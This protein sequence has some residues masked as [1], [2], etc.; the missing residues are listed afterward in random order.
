MLQAQALCFAA[1]GRPIVRDAALSVR[2]GECVGLIGPNG[3]GKI[4]R[5]SCRERV[6][7]IV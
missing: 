1:G 2:A 5:A 6:S 4:G 3:C 7:T